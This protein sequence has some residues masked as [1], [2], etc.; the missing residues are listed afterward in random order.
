MKSKKHSSFL[1]RKKL[2]SSDAILLFFIKSYDLNTGRIRLADMKEAMISLGFDS[3][4]KR[5]FGKVNES[6][7]K[8]TDGFI[9][10]ED[11][12]DLVGANMV[13]NG[14]VSSQ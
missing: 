8:I 9:E 4:H 12:M 2:A 5:L 14:F 3:R 10:F 6:A 7:E 13:W 11:F 1:T